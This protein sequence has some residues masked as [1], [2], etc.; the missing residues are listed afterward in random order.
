MNPEKQKQYRNKWDAANM[1]NVACRLRKDTAER[2]S[3]LAK[4]NGTTPNELI[5]KWITE[6]IK[7][8]EE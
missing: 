1:K 3:E 2:F 5:R 4:Q 7:A 8:A 6:Y